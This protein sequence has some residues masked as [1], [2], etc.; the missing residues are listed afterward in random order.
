MALRYYRDPKAPGPLC[1]GS[2]R[3]RGARGGKRARAATAPTWQH[4][5]PRRRQQQSRQPLAPSSAAA[6]DEATATN[7]PSGTATDTITGVRVPTAAPNSG[8]E[9]GVRAEKGRGQAPRLWVRGRG[10]RGRGRSEPRGRGDEKTLRQRRRL[11]RAAD[12]AAAGFV[13][14]DSVPSS[15]EHAGNQQAGRRGEGEGRSRRRR[16]ATRRSGSRPPAGN[17]DDPA[18][19]FYP[20]ACALV[21]VSRHAETVLERSVSVLSAVQALT[22]TR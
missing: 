8:Q 18:S 14:V 6:E 20:A 7:L 16:E 17:R 22:T 3:G 4:L 19:S 9:G 2:L 21:V 13:I 15:A 10:I 12:T 5:L 1:R 11:G